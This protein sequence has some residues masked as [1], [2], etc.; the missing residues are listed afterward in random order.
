MLR[1]WLWFVLAW[2][3]T[4]C[5][6]EGPLDDERPIVPAGQREAL[7]SSIA[8]PLRVEGRYVV[9]ANYQRVKLK[10]VNWYGAHL[11]RQVVGGLEHQ[12]LDKLVSLITEW[13]FNSVRLTFSNLMIHDQRPVPA[14]YLTANPELQGMTPLQVFDRTVE[15]LSRAG[16]LVILNNHTT[17]SEWCCGFDYNGLWYH[18]G[19]SFAYNQTPEMWQDDWL[20]MVQRYRD[21]P[22]VVGADLRNE[23]RTMR[24]NDTHLPESPNWGQRNHNDWQLA[25]RTLGDR[26]TRVHPGMLVIVEGIN[27]WGAIPILGSGERPHLK[28]VRDLPV[29]LRL[30]DRL[31]YAA[32]NYAFVGPRHNGDDGTSAGNIKY[33]QMDAGTLRSTLDQEWGYVTEAD[34]YYTA[35]VW[36]SEFGVAR[37][38]PSPADRAW[39]GRFV[40]YLIENDLDFAYWPLNDEGFGLVS[41]DWSRTLKDDWRY[42]HLSRL[43]AHTGRQ[44]QVRATHFADLNIQKG[45]DNQSPLD[46]D[47]LAGA[48]KG[49]CADGYRLV[50]L[51]RDQR[52][53]C[54]DVGTGALGRAQGP[55]SVQAVYESSERQHVGY[56]WAGGF[57]KYE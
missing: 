2:S 15:A 29:H 54:S 19:S 38:D 39:F 26:I 44:G 20:A 32:H 34:R 37:S 36:V 1:N 47:W 13:G 14:Q 42:E 48:A 3:V 30:A 27:W 51:S 10:S 18:T 24:F 8:F 7:V 33:G 55:R 11:E 31:V 40:D 17:F 53:L 43:L 23:V 41:S 4:A 9:D 22:W 57:T 46:E 49:T 25:S 6:A 21:N 56:D 35:P 16:I 52:A 50:G 12:P 5:A 45:D 28:P